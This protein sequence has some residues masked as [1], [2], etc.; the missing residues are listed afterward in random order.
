MPRNAIGKEENFESNIFDEIGVTG[1]NRF[2]GTIAEELLSQLSDLYKSNK[3][4]KEMRDND[5]IVGAIMFAT[6]MYIRKTRWYVKAG[7][8]S[9]KALAKAE[10]L[11]SC[12]DD[13]DGQNWNDIIS[14]I[15]SM[16]V[17]GWSTAE[18]VY[19]IRN[20]KNGSKYNDNKIGWKRWGFRAQETLFE[21]IYN[22]E[23]HELAGLIQSDPVTG[24]NITIPMEKLLLFRTKIRKDNP[25]GAS[26]FRNAY[27]PYWY[28]KKLEEFE[29]IGLEHSA[30]GVLCGWVPKKVITDS[31]EA[32]LKNHFGDAIRKIQTGKGASILLPLEYNDKGDKKFDLTFLSTSNDSSK[33]AQIGE[34]INRYDTRIAQT[35]M[36]EI[37]MVGTGKTGSFALAESKSNAFVMA[38][39][40]F[41]EIIKTVINENAVKELLELNGFDTNEEMPT[42]EFMPI[43]KADL[44]EVGQYLKDLATAGAKIWPNRSLQKFIMEI[45]NMPVQ[46]D[47]EMEEQI[48]E[49]EDDKKKMEEKDDEEIDEQD[50]EDEEEE[51]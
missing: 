48:Q 44:K 46:T 17:F 31:S 42:F 15:L 41:L 18:K 47:E 26:I 38:L 1:L 13:F 10:F 3:A 40:T 32:T 25:Q 28:K 43:V 33:I 2:G 51:E 45:A 27:K 21:W 16:L 39:T 29:A 11:D 50:K 12:K 34:V 22:E 37:M 23:N 35:V 30:V 9:Q 6:D 7:G 5:P 20:K 19:K 8:I 24:R 49:K 14:E 36:Y 4:F